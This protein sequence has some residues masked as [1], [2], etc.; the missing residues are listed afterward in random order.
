MAHKSSSTFCQ[1]TRPVMVDD[2]LKFLHVSTTEILFVL[3]CVFSGRLSAELWK[4]EEDSF[5][6]GVVDTGHNSL[7]KA[8]SKRKGDSPRTVQLKDLTQNL[9]Q[10][11]LINGKNQLSKLPLCTRMLLALSVSKSPS[12]SPSQQVTAMLQPPNLPGFLLPKE[13]TTH[14]HSTTCIHE[15]RNANKTTEKFTQSLPEKKTNFYKIFNFAL[16]LATMRRN[17]DETSASPEDTPWCKS[18]PWS[19]P[20]PPKTRGPLEPDTCFQKLRHVKKT[21]SVPKVTIANAP[22]SRT[23][24]AHLGTP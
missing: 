24:F 14:R 7:Q 19:L 20:S 10:N 3:Q 18:S 15:T 11:D 2:G 23:S 21:W 17:A 9:N 4:A 1:Q 5:Q 22:N 6:V 12:H 16:A 8:F 13:S